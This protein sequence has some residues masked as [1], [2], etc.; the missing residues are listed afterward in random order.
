VSATVTAA[1]TTGAVSVVN[2]IASVVAPFGSTQTVSLA[3]VFKT[4]SLDAVTGTVVTMPVTYGVGANS[5]SGAVNFELFDQAT[6]LTVANF[7]RYVNSGSYA[8]SVIHRSLPGFVIQGGGY[9]VGAGAADLQA[10]PTAPPIANEFASSPRVGGKVNVRG[11]LAVARTFDPNS[12]TSQFFVNLVDNSS[13]LDTQSG[14]FATFGRVIGN[15]LNVVDQIASIPTVDLGGQG[16]FSSVPLADYNGTLAAAN[17][18]RFGNVAVVPNPKG[19]FTYTASSS[20]PGNVAVSVTAAGAL[21]VQSLSSTASSAI[22]TVTATDL[23][24]ASV[25]TTFSVTTGNVPKPVVDVLFGGQVI[26]AGQGTPIGL[27]STQVGQSRTVQ[28]TVR[29]TGTAAAVLGQVTLPGGLSVVTGLPSSLAVGASAN[30]ILAVDTSAARVISGNVTIATDGVSGGTIAVPVSGS[31]VSVASPSLAVAINGSSVSSGQAGVVSLGTARVGDT[32]TVTVDL[33]NTGSGVLHLSSLT[34]PTGIV[35]SGSLPGSVDPGGSVRVTLTVS[36]DS[37]RTVSGNLVVA[38]DSAGGAFSVPVTATVQGNA[39]TAPV[40]SLAPVQP[41]PA[42]VTAIDLSFVFRSTVAIDGSSLDDGNVTVTDPAGATLPVTLVTYALVNSPTEGTSVSATYRLSAPNGGFKTGRYFVNLLAN[43]VRDTL[44]NPAVGNR[45]GL[46]T[47]TAATTPK[48][49]GADS[50]FGN[51][52]GSVTS[53]I[54]STSVSVLDTRTDGDGFVTAGIDAQGRLIL[55]RLSADGTLDQTFGTQG[56][57]LI[58]LP[59]GFSAVSLS[60]D[61]DG[62]IL[63]TGTSGTEAKPALLRRNGDGTADTSLGNGAPL[64]LTDFDP[65]D[66]IDAATTL[67]T[68]RIIVAGARSGGKLV[69]ARVT[70]DGVLDP[71]FGTR[72]QFTR[73]ASTGDVLTTI[74][75]AP[76]GNIMAA[77][78]VGSKVAVIRLSARGAE[79]KA[80]SRMAGGVLPSGTGFA[81]ADKV[82]V[83]GDGKIV[84]SSSTA[85]SGSGADAGNFGS[86]VVRLN[87]TG[88]PDSTFNKGNG[89]TVIVRQYQGQGSS[90]PASFKGASMLA[91]VTQGST[92]KGAISS[93]VGLTIS[94]NRIQVYE[95][96]N[97][98]AGAVLT[99]TRIIA[100]GANLT[101]GLTLSKASLKKGQKGMA[102]VTVANNGTLPTSG[103]F[104]AKLVFGNSGISKDLTTSQILKSLKNGVR[105]TFKFN[106]T[107]EVDPGSY[108]VY[109]V[110]T[111]IDPLQDINA[112]D[113]TTATTSLKVT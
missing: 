73:L 30:L 41:V 3:G 20:D 80:F 11:T 9:R 106:F 38:S 66:T 14:G 17:Y 99:V 31:V 15:G 98:T 4:T 50:N 103:T 89:G 21:S 59:T 7:L 24:G 55:S 44:G 13:N 32:L 83:Q 64:L 46:F 5:F 48:V 92:V 94:N 100:D 81:T 70:P 88:T 111:P 104:S 33:S 53:A 79:D 45:Y 28:F 52:S 10:I 76:N 23:A 12:A 113:N 58:T 34:P 62:K 25:K 2:P 67:T 35:L 63:L 71:T 90:T 22:I 18:V 93:K 37:V 69:V 96:N 39:S 49:G 107:V 97:V 78:T 68:G 74:A 108:D 40:V 54:S 51:G 84:F 42:S 26:P 16:L 8:G 36:T 60:F 87:A 6:P 61:P 85:A 95:A 101:P 86:A 105:Q 57:K 1:Q 109:L 29:N 82:V 19:Y 27:G 56:S 65:L 110:F 75:I 77:G 47:V 91:A 102:V 72:G 112:G 43:Q